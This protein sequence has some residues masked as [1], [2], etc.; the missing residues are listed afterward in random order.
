MWKSSARLGSLTPRLI[1]LGLVLF[2]LSNVGV[3]GATHPNTSALDAE[4]TTVPWQVT[5][6]G[7]GY[8]TTSGYVLSGTVGQ[9]AV[10]KGVGGDEQVAQGFWQSFAP[11][12]CGDFDGNGFVNISDAVAI[13]SYVFVT[14]PPPTLMVTADAD[15]NGSVNISDAVYLIAFIFRV[16]PPPCANC[17]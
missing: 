14:G 6:A 11:F 9:T 7:G 16:G 13:T 2:L 15:C 3:T 4:G 17:N 1:G 5:G 8:G 10:I 12:L